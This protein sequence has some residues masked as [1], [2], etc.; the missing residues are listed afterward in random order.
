MKR[1]KRYNLEEAKIDKNKKYTI[2]EAIQKSVET[3]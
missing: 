3:S 2:V 1:S